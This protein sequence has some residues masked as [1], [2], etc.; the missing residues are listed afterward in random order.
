M[1]V[2]RIWRGRV[3]HA[4]AD[5]YAGYLYDGGPRVMLERLGALGV[6]MFRREVDGVTEFTVQSYWPSVEAMR[7]W[8]GADVTRVRP[9]ERD[10]ELLLELPEFVEIHAVPFN[11]WQMAG[12]VAG[13]VPVAGRHP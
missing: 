9:L 12:T 8:A 1:T 5:F 3:R 2:V 13:T 7:A 11:I 10:A 4:D 6:Q